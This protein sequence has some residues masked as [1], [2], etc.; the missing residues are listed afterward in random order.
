MNDSL[1]LLEMTQGKGLKKQEK[2]HPSLQLPL[3]NSDSARCM[4]ETFPEYSK[5]PF[6][7]SANSS[8]TTFLC[9]QLIHFIPEILTQFRVLGIWKG[10]E[11][12]QFLS[13]IRPESGWVLGED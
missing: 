1:W 12:K 11:E 6:L 2:F 4:Q 8:R 3:V 7:L 10:F 9:F 5:N 13:G